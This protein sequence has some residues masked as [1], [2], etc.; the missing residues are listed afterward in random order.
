MRQIF[1]GYLRNLTKRFSG[2]LRNFHDYLQTNMHVV[3]ILGNLAG[4]K[5]V[6]LGCQQTDN[7]RKRSEGYVFL[8]TKEHPEG[9][10]LYW[11]G[12]TT[13]GGMYL[14]QETLPVSAQGYD[15]PQAYVQRSL[16]PGSGEENYK[17]E[18]FHDAQSLPALERSWKTCACGSKKLQRTPLGMVEAWAG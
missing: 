6:L 9:E 12:G 7:G 3:S 16:S 15:Y 4:D 10:V 11:E 2:R 1:G 8:R 5:A 13:T 17:W 18:D 14:R